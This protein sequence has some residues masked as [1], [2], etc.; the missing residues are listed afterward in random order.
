MRLQPETDETMHTPV[1]HPMWSRGIVS[2]PND[3][4]KMNTVTDAHR[5]AATAEA[6]QIR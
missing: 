5:S 4:L 6:V 2:N 3:G 1:A